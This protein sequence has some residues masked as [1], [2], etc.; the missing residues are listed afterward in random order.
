[1]QLIESVEGLPSQGQGMVELSKLASWKIILVMM[2]GNVVCYIKADALMHIKQDRRTSDL[3][4]ISWYWRMC[5][6]IAEVSPKHRSSYVI[7]LN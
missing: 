3:C 1:M 6:A 7:S 4:G 2:T 5:N